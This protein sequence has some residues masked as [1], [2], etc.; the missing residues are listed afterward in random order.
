MSAS[1]FVLAFILT[2]DKT[3][4]LVRGNFSFTDGAGRKKFTP[5]VVRN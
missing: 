4:L 3:L 1:W 5:L 2:G